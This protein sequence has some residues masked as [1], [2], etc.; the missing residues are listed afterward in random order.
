MTKDFR[1]STFAAARFSTAR[2]ALSRRSVGMSVHI[3]QAGNH[4]PSLEVTTGALKVGWKR[5]LLCND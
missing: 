5:G 3:D 1:F 4:P 2:L